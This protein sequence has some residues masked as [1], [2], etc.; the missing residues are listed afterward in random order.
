MTKPTDDA[1]SNFLNL[2]LAAMT[3]AALER[4]LTQLQTSLVPPGTTKEKVVRII[5]IPEEMDYIMG[6]S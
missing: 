1:T 5:I 2:L 3:D 4:K 6:G